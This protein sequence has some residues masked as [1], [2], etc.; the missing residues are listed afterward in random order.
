MIENDTIFDLE[1]QLL[2]CW[3]VT[4][5]IDLITTHFVD[6]P[7]WEGMSVELADALMNKY[8][9]I[10]ELYELKFSRCWSTFEKHTQ[11]YHAYRKACTDQKPL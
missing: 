11:D 3:K 9:A 2:D 6:D 5:D 10:K 1:Q 7:K 8:F 4:D